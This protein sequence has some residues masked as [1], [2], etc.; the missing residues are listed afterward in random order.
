MVCVH[1]HNLAFYSICP[2][3]DF[4]L[5]TI[6]SIESLSED[7]CQLVDLATEKP[8][9]QDT[10]TLSES[11]NEEKRRKEKEAEALGEVHENS[12]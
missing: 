11:E 4:K 12:S 3:I 1:V 6:K 8:S 10:G 2:H 7:Q 5:G 9:F